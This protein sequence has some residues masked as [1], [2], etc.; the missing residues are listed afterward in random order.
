MIPD[1]LPAGQRRRQ[2]VDPR[3]TTRPC[4][5]TGRAPIEAASLGL[6]LPRRPGRL[7]LQP[8]HRRRRRDDGRLRR[9]SS[10]HRATPPRSSRRSTP[11]SARAPG[12]T[13]VEFHPGVQYRHIMVAPADWADA[14]VHPAPRP[15]R[16]AGACGRPVRRAAAPRGD[17]GEPRRCWPGSDLAANQI[18]LWGQG[19]QPR[20]RRSRSTYGLPAG[21]VTAVDLVRGLGVLTDMDVPDVD[22]R[23]RLV[24]HRLRGQARRRARRRSRDGADLFVI[25]VEATDEAG[26]AGDVDEKV[27]ALENCGPRRPRR[28]GPGARRDGAVAA[29]AAARPRHAAAAARPTRRIPV[30]YL[31]VDSAVDGPGRHL[32]RAWRRRTPPVVPGHELMARLIGA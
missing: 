32:H 10:R 8:R 29:A 1:G 18:W 6:K 9:W 19:F 26:H 21:M 31:L 20:C 24:R 17:G 28:P 16:P 11:S 12:P 4:F 25:H 13:V 14:D 7:P 30:P 3:A 22:G 2:H 15:H 23:D 27:R 5:H